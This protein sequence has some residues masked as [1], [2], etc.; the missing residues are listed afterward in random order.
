MMKNSLKETSSFCCAL[1]IKYALER[2]FDPKILFN[3]IEDKKDVLLSAHEWISMDLW[4]QLARNFEQAGGNLFDAGYEIMQS[5]TP[6]FMYLFFQIAGQDFIIKNTAKHFTE[7]LVKTVGLTI[8]PK[9]KGIADVVF[10]PFP[11]TCYST[12]NCD[13]Y[14][15]CTLAVA[16]LKKVRNLQLTELTCAVRGNGHECRYRLTWIPDP[17]LLER[18]R[19]SI[20]L[21]FKT[22]KA[23][24]SNMEEMYNT[25]QTQYNEAKQLNEQL[26]VTLAE[27]AWLSETLQD[28]NSNLERKVAEQ[29]SDIRAKNETL[30]KTNA[31]L[32]ESERMKDLLTGA[33]VHDIK[34]HLFSL[35]SDVRALNDIEGC[36]QEAHEILSHT[37][38][39]CTSAMSLAANML[40]IG[41]MEEGRLVVE[42]QPVNFPQIQTMLG[43]YIQ[44]VFFKEKKISVTV[45]PPDF[46]LTFDADYYLLDRVLQNLLTNAAMYTPEEG[47]VR[48]TFVEPATIAVF[49]SGE[50]IPEKY[51]GTLFEKYARVNT[52]SSKYA[53]G[54]GLFFCR[55]VMGAHGGSIELAC[56]ENGNRFV[57]RFHHEPLNHGT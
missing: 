6:Y 32:R 47:E 9:R 37:S 29:T 2:K 35:A 18:L 50:P 55:L 41:K 53:K 19:D 43:R 46:D 48:I 10:T 49:N 1:M 3:G 45:E 8:E 20:F 13:F 15:G 40:D 42:L 33:L 26:T 38:S 36:S 24:L 30:I 4:I 14:R 56:S 16:R 23:I 25:L 5:K 11:N 52:D 34:N 21:R 7:R 44:N 22:Q 57:L 51:R 31:Q 54:L 12:Q 39:A 17:S 28:L 27:K